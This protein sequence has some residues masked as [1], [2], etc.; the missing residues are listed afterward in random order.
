MASR[1]HWARKCARTEMGRIA[2][3]QPDYFIFS[4]LIWTNIVFIAH[5]DANRLQLSTMN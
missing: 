5:V 2:Q 1:F 3:S 4:N